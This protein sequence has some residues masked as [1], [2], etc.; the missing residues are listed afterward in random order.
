MCRTGRP[1]LDGGGGRVA[2]I[3][4]TRKPGAAIE[5]ASRATQHVSNAAVSAILGRYDYHGPILTVTQ[6]G[7]HLFAQLGA[8]PKYEIFAESDTTYFWKVVEARVTFIKDAGGRVISATHDQGGRTIDAPRLEDPDITLED[9]QSDPILGNYD[10]GDSR[11]MAISRDA[12]HLFGQLTG[13]PRRELGA[14][15]A[16]ELYL[17]QWNARYTVLKDPSGKVTALISH[18]NG[19]DHEWQKLE[20]P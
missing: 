19:A 6:E 15:S 14:A 13:Q 4:F 5:E 3:T 9:V 1:S 12:G 7:D 18:Q 16:T 17:K 10:V 8:Q 11:R 20:G 2:G